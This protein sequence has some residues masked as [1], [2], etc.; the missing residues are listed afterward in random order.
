MNIVVEHIWEY[1]QSNPSLS[2]PVPPS[3]PGSNQYIMLNT[4]A[5]L[6]IGGELWCESMEAD[7]GMED[8]GGAGGPGGAG[9]CG[10]RKGGRRGEKE[11]RKGMKGGRRGRSNNQHP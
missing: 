2:R 1:V 3:L 9:G 5:D 8:L 11:D 6:C 7:F 10:G 4:M